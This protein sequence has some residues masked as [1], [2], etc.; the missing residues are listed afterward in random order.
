MISVDLGGHELHFD[1]PDDAIITGAVGVVTYQR[2]DN[3]DAAAGTHWA[4]SSIPQHQAV[5]MIR[6][7]QIAIESPENY[8]LGEQ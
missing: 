2:L 1:I 3:G 4:T 6:L 5:G 7:A 8:E